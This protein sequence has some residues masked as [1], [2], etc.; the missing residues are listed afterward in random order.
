MVAMLLAM[1]LIIVVNCY[2]PCVCSGH[3]L[4]TLYQGLCHIFFIWFQTR[5]LQQLSNRVQ[6]S[7]YVL[8]AGSESIQMGQR[9][10]ISP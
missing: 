9:Y 8:W 10:L 6:F 3:V 2:C 4:K 1:T 7:E 5:V